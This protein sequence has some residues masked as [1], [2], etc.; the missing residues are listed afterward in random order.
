LIEYDWLNA[1]YVA[2]LMAAAIR[3]PR[4]C[5]SKMIKRF[6]AMNENRK[7]GLGTLRQQTSAPKDRIAEAQSPDSRTAKRTASGA[8]RQMGVGNGKRYA[9]SREFCTLSGLRGALQ[10]KLAYFKLLG[11]FLGSLILRRM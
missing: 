9:V 5:V 4:P 11:A 6:V 8:F 10:F 1:A 7:M 2:K 3:L